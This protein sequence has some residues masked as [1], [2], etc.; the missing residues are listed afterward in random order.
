[1]EKPEAFVLKA[2]LPGVKTDDLDVQANGNRITVSGKREEEKEEKGA[3]E[4]RMERSYGSFSR[5]FALP[6][7][8]DSSKVNAELKDGVLTL[9][10]PKKVVQPA[11]P[12][13]V[14]AS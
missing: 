3:T 4:Y 11:T 10:V 2:D 13:K 14:K 5:S 8:I 6:E 1:K 9:T 12:I 7:A